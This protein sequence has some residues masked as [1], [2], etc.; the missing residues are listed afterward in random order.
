MDGQN[1]RGLKWIR[2]LGKFQKRRPTFFQIYGMSAYACNKMSFTQL[3]NLSC[4]VA[5]TLQMKDSR[6]ANLTFHRAHNQQNETK[7][8]KIA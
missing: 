1:W 4:H 8:P 2:H 6:S 3:E 5:M 7:L